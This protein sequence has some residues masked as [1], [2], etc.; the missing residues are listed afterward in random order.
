MQSGI[1][2]GTA[3]ATVKHPSLAGQKMIV[4]QFH[5]VDGA[6]PD[7]E[8]VIAVDLLGAAVGQHVILSSDGKQTRTLL[9]SETTPV[10]WSVIGI[11]D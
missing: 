2:L 9:G 6:S 8:P 10:R 3:T 4:V 5:A 1:V 7:G 11:Q